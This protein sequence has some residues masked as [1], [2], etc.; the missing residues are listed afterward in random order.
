MPDDKIIE[1]LSKMLRHEQS[2]RAIGSVA[3]AEAFATKIQELLTEHKLEMSE[4]EFQERDK[5]EIA[6]QE[7]NAA[8]MERI[9]VKREAKQI[10]WQQNIAWSI[11]GSN[12]CKILVF[13]NSNRTYFVGK[14]SDRQL[15]IVLYA[16][17][18]RMALEMAAKHSERD[19][20][21]QQWKC[22]ARH[23]FSD[24]YSGAIFA[25]WMRDYRKSFC[26]GFSDALTVRFVAAARE[27]E[28]RKAERDGAQCSALVHVRKDMDAVKDWIEKE[29]RAA[30]ARGGKR[31]VKTDE[32]QPLHAEGYKAGYSA[33]ETVALTPHA[34]KGGK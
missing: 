2:A 15:C 23:A 19:Y 21:H 1:K 4:I 29:C 20:S 32:H 9:G 16:H 5:E 11:A 34:L 26:N 30:V 17:F 33:G 25:Q 31:K 7:P 6:A 3:E 22:K 12:T 27:V 10:L 14:T 28:R 13:A 18:V 24:T 8:E